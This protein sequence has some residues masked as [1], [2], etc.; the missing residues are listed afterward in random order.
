MK[1]TVREIQSV[2]EYLGEQDF[3]AR[4]KS[5]YRADL[6]AFYNFSHN[7]P[8]T[9]QNVRSWRDSM[10]EKGNSDEHISRRLFALK[11]YCQWM[12]LDI[13]SAARE[14]R[15]DKVKSPVMRFREPPPVC[16]IEDIDKLFKACRTPME[17]ALMMLLTGLS[18]PRISEL[19]GI[20]IDNDIDWKNK[21]ISLTRKGWR[22]RKQKV[23][24]SDSVL[25]SIKEYLKWRDSKSRLLLPYTYYELRRIFLGLAERAGVKFPPYSLFHNLRHFFALYQ[26]MA[27]TD[28]GNISLAM[29]HSNSYITDRIYGKLDPGEIKR[30]TAPLPWEGENDK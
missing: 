11:G 2:E 30:R 18:G 20:N 14:K 22:G 9:V 24:V 21:T 6:V 25:G 13:F 15:R 23:A 27:D 17:R 10:V 4:T 28:M 3:S 8:P 26:K 7:E 1:S 29:G 19:M 16:T 5:G 12:G